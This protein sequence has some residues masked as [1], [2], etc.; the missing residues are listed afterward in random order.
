MSSARAPSQ[1]FHQMARAPQMCFDELGV[2]YNANGDAPAVVHQYN[3]FSELER[4]ISH[5]LLP[6]VAAR[7]A[8]PLPPP[9]PPSPQLPTVAEA[10]TEAGVLPSKASREARSLRDERDDAV[11]TAL[12]AELRA[13][14][15]R[16]RA[17]FEARLAEMDGRLAQLQ[18]RVAEAEAR[19]RDRC[20]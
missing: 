20:G 15:E 16:L 6:T 19:A 1:A 17:A 12:A 14:V 18:T 4:R 13:E 8:P 2:F 11:G 7:P 5:R 10:G 9:P 3:R